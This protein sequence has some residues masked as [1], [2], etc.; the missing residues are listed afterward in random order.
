MKKRFLS[1]LLALVLCLGLTIPAGASTPSLD[2]QSVYEAM[3][4]LKDQYPQGMKWNNEDYYGW[5]GGVYTG[6][7]GCA[8]FAFLL[9]DAA[10]GDLP[11]RVIEDFQFSDIRPGD[12]LRVEGNT[13]SVIVLAING[14]TL[15]LAEGNY[16]NSINWGRTMTANQVVLAD[17]LMTRY[18]E[19]GADIPEPEPEPTPEPTPEPI[20]EPTPKPTPEPTPQPTPGPIPEPTPKPTPEPIP[21]PTPEP[22]P[23]PVPEVSI[24]FT[25]VPDGIWYANSVAWGV[26]QR[27]VYGM[28]STTFEPGTS[29]TQAQILTFLYRA[30]NFPDVEG[31]LPFVV[32]DAYIKPLLWADSQGI[33]DA[34][35]FDPNTACTR[36]TAVSYIWQAFG[37]LDAEPS[38]F[39]DVD[40]QADYAAAVSWAVEKKVTNGTGIG[41]F[42]PE[43]VCDRGTII[44]FLYRAYAPS[45]N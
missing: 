2:P 38:T 15:T 20:P 3:I 24:T 27:I 37:S 16:N 31:K 9:S 36:A 12:I 28:T 10:F 35:N 43:T 13:H 44:T 33:I 30:A 26:K 17:Y 11:A 14:N 18:P 6:G 5:H 22:I 19:S 39:T 8:G 34:K 45:S 40:A 25:D 7:Y 21:A 23:E 1:M 32:A 4:A 29:C 42:S 41:I